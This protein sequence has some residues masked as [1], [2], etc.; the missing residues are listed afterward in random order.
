MAYH[1][2]HLMSLAVEILDII[3]SNIESHKDLISL[4]AS[5]RLCSSLVIPRHTEYRVLRIGTRHAELW[6][7]LAKRADLARNIRVLYLI[8]DFDGFPAPVR[9]PTTFVDSEKVIVFP[10]GEE[11][12]DV[13]AQDIARAIRNIESL[14]K[15]VWIQPWASGHIHILHHNVRTLGVLARIP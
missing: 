13:R 15:F 6:E 2:S 14:Q 3:C 7:H 12:E 8:E 1:T 9:H 5:S 4:A 11:G 10:E